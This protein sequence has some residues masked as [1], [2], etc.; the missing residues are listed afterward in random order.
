MLQSSS[1]HARYLIEANLATVYTFYCLSLAASL[2]TQLSDSY[3]SSIRKLPCVLP[4]LK[5]SHS[6][7]HRPPNLE[8]A[9]HTC[10][11]SGRSIHTHVQ[12]SHTRVG[13]SHARHNQ[14]CT[15]VSIQRSTAYRSL[16]DKQF[17]YAALC[18]HVPMMDDQAPWAR[19]C[20]WCLCAQATYD[21]Y[22]FPRAVL[23]L[24]F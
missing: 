21:G 11:V 4:M 5:S 23:R 14:V 24:T 6:L 17:H 18:S 22:R 12:C 19:L 20:I 15:T 8:G 13:L 1:G 9:L 16:A 2:V 3:H 7:S 10:S